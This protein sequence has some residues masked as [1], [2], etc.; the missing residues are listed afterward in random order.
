MMSGTIISSDSL[1]STTL[2]V[3]VFALHLIW[4]VFFFLWYENAHASV[5]WTYIFQFIIFWYIIF[6]F[7]HLKFARTCTHC[8]IRLMMK[9]KLINT[10]KAAFHLLSNDILSIWIQMTCAPVS[11]FDSVYFEAFLL[12]HSMLALFLFMSSNGNALKWNFPN[13]FRCW[14]MSKLWFIIFC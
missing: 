14:K 2:F 10:K 12:M 8:G 4:F 7:Y 3:V 13:V 11:Q 6:Y 1:N 9:K 5:R